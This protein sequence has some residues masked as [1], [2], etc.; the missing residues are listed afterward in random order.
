MKMRSR[1][2][3]TMLATLVL[4]GLLVG[5]QQLQL[6]QNAALPAPRPDTLRLATWNVH[7]ILRNQQT[8]RWGVSG[9]EARKE[10][11]NATFKAINS[12]VL[13]FQE[14]ET[15]SG[16]NDDSENLARSWL[17]ERNPG[18]NAAA[19]GDW[20]EFPSTQ[21]ILYRRDRIEVLDQGWF[22]FSETPDAIYSRTFNGS[23][24]AFATW[25]RFRDRRTGSEFRVVNV[26]L[27]FR[28]TENRRRSTALIVARVEPWI[29]SGETVFLAGDLN[30]RLG[31]DLH[32]MLEETGLS[33]LPV[34][35]ATYHLDRGLNLF[36]AIDHLAYAGTVRPAGPP[37]VFQQK[38]GP[39][40]PAD[41]YPLIGEFEFPAP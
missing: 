36:G 35:A 20:R 9:W 31:S 3:R 5:C 15:F 24:P 21:P 28:S 14:M 30:A 4:A 2:V 12:D 40:W 32:D 37:V 17:L 6:S 19:I 26:H 8:G 25:A 7:Y 41:H 13:A 29:A 34:A 27:D 22:F 18:Y 16:G 23:Y 10:P 1:V 11:M 38:L 33:F 39:V